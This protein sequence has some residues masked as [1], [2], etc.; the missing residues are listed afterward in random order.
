MNPGLHLL[1]TQ[2]QTVCPDGTPLAGGRLLAP[3]GGEEIGKSHNKRETLGS[4]IGT[5]RSM[6]TDPPYFPPP[7]SEGRLGCSQLS[8][9]EAVPHYLDATGWQ[10]ANMGPGL[11][12][13]LRGTGGCG[14]GRGHAGGGGKERPR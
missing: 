4:G 14:E 11:P 10:E 13:L 7:D 8:S 1:C 5:Q 3:Q 6:P 9:S 2:P 12:S